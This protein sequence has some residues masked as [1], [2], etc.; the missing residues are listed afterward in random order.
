MRT[1]ADALAELIA[2]ATG[3]QRS[4]A[5]M[6]AAELGIADLLRGGPRAVD[7]LAEATQTHAP[8]LYRLLRALAAAAVFREKPGRVFAL[9]PM[10]EFLRSD[11]AV[12]YGHLVR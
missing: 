2:V 3:Y 10:S 9:T 5:L 4:R 11:S 1:R 12:P 8:T 6:V 7:D